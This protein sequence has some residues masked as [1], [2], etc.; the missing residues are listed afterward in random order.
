[1]KRRPLRKNIRVAIHQ[2][3]GYRCRMCGR[4]SEVTTLHVDH[5]VPVADGGT[6]ALENLATLCADCN[7]GK[8][9][10]RL[11]DYR[12]GPVGSAGARGAS[13]SSFDLWTATLGQRVRL[14]PLYGA[15]G[16]P[17]PD[18]WFRVEDV[19]AA[20]VSFSKDSTSQHITL[21]MF[22]LSDP[23]DI[24][25]GQGARAVVRQGQLHFNTQIQRWQWR[26]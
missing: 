15:P 24:V 6:D 8:S 20:D 11:P 19:A 1:M 12:G 14:E 26:P 22:C 9:S 16:L 5:I 21:P 17:P 4:S 10:L 7:T 23:F 18:P 2:R 25:P 13:T 3:D